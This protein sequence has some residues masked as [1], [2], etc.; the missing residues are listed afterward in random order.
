LF[1]LLIHSSSLRN[2]TIIGDDPHLRRVFLLIA[3]GW[4]IAMGISISW[5]IY[6]VRSGALDLAR[7]GA[8]TAYAKDALYRRWNTQHGGVYVTVTE[9]T[10]PNPY[11]LDV[12]ERDITTPSGRQLTSSTMRT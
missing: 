1:F 12:R 3:A 9:A 2:E 7:E 11:L 10:P 6:R 4:T 5:A 8:A